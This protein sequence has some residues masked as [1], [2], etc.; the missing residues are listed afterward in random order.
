[1][2]RCRKKNRLPALGLNQG[3]LLILKLCLFQIFGG[4]R[5]AVLLL[6]LSTFRRD[7]A[8]GRRI[9]HRALLGTILTTSSG[10]RCGIRGVDS[11]LLK[12]LNFLLGLV[13]VL[14]KLVNT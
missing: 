9:L 14:R 12:L 11:F 3:I 8:I 7:R 5:N 10:G 2:H 1:M 6:R 13:D 4:I